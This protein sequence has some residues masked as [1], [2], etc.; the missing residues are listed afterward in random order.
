MK[1]YSV[2]YAA[3]VPHYATFEIQAATT[4]D[5][6]LAAKA[7]IATPDVTL[8]DPDWDNTILQRIV[9]IEDDAGNAVAND[10]SID[11]QLLLVDS[12]IRDAIQ[13]ALECLSNFKADWLAN[14]GLKA[15]V[16]KLEAAY[17]L[18]GGVA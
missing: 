16:E 7:H 11:G 8:G 2:L 13:Y 14:H 3:D 18:A 17:T 1:A 5:A 10:I 4:E 12:Q 9:H 15:A 6:I